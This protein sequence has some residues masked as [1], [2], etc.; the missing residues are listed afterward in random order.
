MRRKNFSSR[1]R[2]LP[3]EKKILAVAS[4]VTLVSCFL[5]W[6]G[7]N[8]RVINE[9]WNAFSSI[10]SVAG[11]L[12]T[13][14][15][16][17]SLGLLMLPVIKPE[18]DLSK[19]LPMKETSLLIFL[20]AQSLFV[21]LIFIPV[22]AQYSLINAT[23]SG[24]RFGIYIAL[25]STL[26]SAVA[27]LSYQRRAEKLDSRLQEFAQVPRSHRAVDDWSQEENLDAEQDQDENLAENEQETIFME[28]QEEE[29]Y[30]KTMMEDESV[31]SY[32][33]HK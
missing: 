12:V 6:Y 10:G 31:N 30:P 33:Q 27:A 19:K 11:Y 5:P 21:T 22:Y 24:T 1:F 17:V 2:A 16:L 13:V 3:V 32:Q 26:V 7:I 8:S 25:I 20:N 18:W 23:N 4:L 29:Q 9:W 28:N 15:S 14:L